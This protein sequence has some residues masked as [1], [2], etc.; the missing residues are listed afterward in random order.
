MTS[1]LEQPGC[2]KS[3]RSKV[4]LY[5]VEQS[6]C[7]SGGRL[8]YKALP[9]VSSPFPLP[10]DCLCS[11]APWV[12]TSPINCCYRSCCLHVLASINSAAMN[13]GVHVSFSDLVSSVC[14]PR[15]GIAGSYGSSISSFF[16]E[17]LHCSP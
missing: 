5:G 12:C 10:L 8:L 17:S 16:K 2:R 15:S 3:E 6:A 14:M 4:N 7:R 11:S 13:I 1:E 9:Y